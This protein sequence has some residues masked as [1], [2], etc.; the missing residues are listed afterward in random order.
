MKKL[1]TTL[2]LVAIFVFGAFAQKTVFPTDDKGNICYTNKYA[3]SQSKAELFEA[4]NL[5]AVT[6]FHSGDAVFSKDAEKGEVLANGTLKTRSSYNPF[7]GW[8]NEYVTFV[9]KFKVDE[10]S[11]EYTIYRPTLAESYA[12]FGTNS[13]TSS[14]DDKYQTYLKAYADIDAAKKSET[15]SKKDKKSI[16][17]EAEDIIE[18]LGDTMEEAEKSLHDLSKMIEQNLFR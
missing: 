4:A 18:D 17:K 8:F 10:G 2:C 7:A 3:S 14:L 9:V 16:I 1:L 13:K 12:G 5:W 11:I 6:T 15:M